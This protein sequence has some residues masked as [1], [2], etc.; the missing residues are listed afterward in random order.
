MKASLLY[1]FLKVYCTVGLWFYC[2]EWRITGKHNVPKDGPILFIANHQN[3]FLDAILMTCSTNLVPYYLARA[4][5][6]EK[7]WAAK[8][9]SS[10]HIKPVYRI[11]D[12]FSTLKNNE[13]IFQQCVDLLSQNKC[14]LLFPEANHNSAYT[15]REFQKGFARIALMYYKQTGK[16]NLQILPTTLYFTEHHTYLSKVLVQVQPTLK[17]ADYKDSLSN[18][19][20]FYDDLKKDAEQAVNKDALILPLNENYWSALARIKAQRPLQLP[21]TEILNHDKNNMNNAQV[22]AKERKNSIITKT[23]ASIWRMY[24]ILP[25]WLV[26]YVVKHKIKDDQFYSSV[27]FAIGIFSIPAYYLLLSLLVLSF[28]TTSTLAFG[29]PLVG[30]LLSVLRKYFG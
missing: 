19:K 25:V 27:T 20:K 13:A 29:I 28:S 2:K 6:F 22:Y 16:S 4:T 7:K 9:L 15:T 8:L 23:L 3:A 12:G 11:R 18:E 17:L 24:H 14:I 5:V 21:V 26:R 30:L 1:R 10:I